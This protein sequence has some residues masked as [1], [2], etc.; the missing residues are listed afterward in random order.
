M[1]C[2]DTGGDLPRE[3]S[4]RDPELEDE[5]EDDTGAS[6]PRVA[7]RGAADSLGTGAV[8]EALKANGTR[9][10]AVKGGCCRVK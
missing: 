6:T 8:P 9:V 7:D 3:P 5:L 2:R 1:V 4:D 10:G